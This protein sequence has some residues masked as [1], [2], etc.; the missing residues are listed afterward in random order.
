MR[1]RDLRRALNGPIEDTKVFLLEALSDPRRT[2]GL[3]HLLGRLFDD[4]DSARFEVVQK[5]KERD[6]VVPIGYGRLCDR[7][8]QLIVSYEGGIK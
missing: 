2:E 3:L 8:T 1:Q 5:L 6:A 4:Y 7:V